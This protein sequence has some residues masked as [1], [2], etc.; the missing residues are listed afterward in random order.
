MI[1]AKVQCFN[2]SDCYPAVF[3]TLAS[4]FFLGWTEKLAEENILLKFYGYV[5]YAL[6]KKWCKKSLTKRPN[7]WLHYALDKY[8]DSF[9][10]EVAKVLKLA[11]L[12]RPLPLHFALLAQQ[13]S[14]W[15]F[16]ASLMNTTLS[17][18]INL[19]P[20]QAKAIGPVF[21]FI[22]IPFMQYI[23]KPN[24]SPGAKSFGNGLYYL[25]IYT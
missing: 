7:Y 25:L 4:S 2:K 9:V 10:N 1:R 3:G 5:K 11:K 22:L 17:S 23:V 16:Q 15:T 6:A 12:F 21:L 20:D 19:Q 8:D 18:G 24:F 13:D 14:S